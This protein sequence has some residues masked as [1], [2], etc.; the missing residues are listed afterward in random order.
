M[1]QH[2]MSQVSG[3]DLSGVSKGDPWEKVK[4]KGVGG[5]ERKECRPG[6]PLF[7]WTS[8][9]L[10]G[11]KTNSY[12]FLLSEKKVWLY[13]WICSST[14]LVANQLVTCT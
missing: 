3:S 9:G 4:K 7:T 13:L 12:I 6:W 8:C 1:L 5:S 11:A 2:I 10:C 14:I